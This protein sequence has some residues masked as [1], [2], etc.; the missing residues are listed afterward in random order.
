[1][2]VAVYARALTARP[3]GRGLYIREMLAALGRVAP[4]LDLHVFAGE[5]AEIPGCRVY[6]ARG[7]GFIADLWRTLR[8]VARDVAAIRPDVFWS[9][10]PFLPGGLAAD[11]PVVI[12]VHDLVWRDHPE[13]MSAGSRLAAGWMERG[14]RRARRIV[15]DSAFT[16][17]RLAAFWPDRAGVADVIHLAPN[18]RLRAAAPETGL[19]D[20]LEIRRP[21]VL[22]VGTLEPRKNLPVLLEAMQALP[23]VTLVQ[24]GAEGWRVEAL[25]REAGRMP[26]MKRLGYVDESVLA[27]LYRDAL[28]AVFP[29]RYEGF[30]L[31][32]LDAAAAGCPVVVSDIPVHREVLGDA[33]VYAPLDDAAALADRIR[34]LRDDPAMRAS[35]AQRLQA[36]AARFSW[37]ASAGRFIG[38][39]QDAAEGRLRPV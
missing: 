27:A 33:A 15:C 32:P 28:A 37:E 2:K 9:A 7:A 35:V 18:P 25:L 8:G 16:R 13:T 29:S 34:T 14:I 12:T 6:P 1:V 38:I 30:H 22:N 5:P 31:P 24:C 26:N 17:D 23:D 36:H 11:R 4:D 10:S 19:V 21:F 39:L 20:R 3:T